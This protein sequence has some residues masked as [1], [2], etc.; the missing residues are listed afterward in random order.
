[1]NKNITDET[2]YLLGKIALELI[3]KNPNFACSAT[4]Y[5][6]IDRLENNIQQWSNSAN[7]LKGKIQNNKHT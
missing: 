3:N 4:I 6:D 2:I 5:S 7:E 1:M